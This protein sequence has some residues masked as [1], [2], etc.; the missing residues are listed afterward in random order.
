MLPTGTTLSQAREVIMKEFNKPFTFYFE[1]M[2]SF[3]EEHM[4]NKLKVK[5][6]Q[7]SN[8]NFSRLKLVENILQFNLKIYPPQ[9]KKTSHQVNK[10]QRKKSKEFL[11]V[12]T[13]AKPLTVTTNLQ[14]WRPSQTITGILK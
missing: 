11:T 4:E 6:Q 14:T 3:V 7:Q 13:K 5:S 1:K 10:S 9:K 12:K 2:K 8:L